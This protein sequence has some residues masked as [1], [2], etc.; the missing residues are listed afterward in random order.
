MTTGADLVGAEL[1]IATREL[2]LGVRWR[3]RE[4]AA[5]AKDMMPATRDCSTFDV[6]PHDPS[7]VVE[8]NTLAK[9]DPKGKDARSLVGSVL[10]I[11][12]LSGGLVPFS[13]SERK[14]EM[15]PMIG[16]HGY[17]GPGSIFYNLAPDDTLCMGD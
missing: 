9:H 15:G 11:I 7:L 16:M 5:F 2:L 8:E 10:K 17:F 4:A 12:N 3:V 6:E 1:V 13:G 14:A